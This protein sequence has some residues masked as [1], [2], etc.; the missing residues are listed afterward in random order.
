MVKKLK[1]KATF[2]PKGAEKRK[3][4]KTYQEAWDLWKQLLPIICIRLLTI[5]VYFGY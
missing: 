5:I 2:E 1:G 3:R 4:E